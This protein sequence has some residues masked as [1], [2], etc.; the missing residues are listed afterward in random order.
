EDRGA[1]GAEPAPG[2]AHACQL[3]VGNLTGRSRELSPQLPGRLDQQED[4]PH[5]RVAGGEAA[6]VGV[7]RQLTAH[8]ELAVGHEGAAVALLA[9]A[10]ALERQEDHA[11]EG[12]VQLTYVDV[13]R[14]D[15]G[16]TE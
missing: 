16:P 13:V 11:G 5:A 6:T 14:G 9:E 1:A 3:R 12:V 10:Q 15:A 8:A 4:A 7:R 2:C